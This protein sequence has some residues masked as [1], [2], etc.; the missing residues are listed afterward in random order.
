MWQ[1]PEMAEPAVDHEP[2]I[3]VI[4]DVFDLTVAMGRVLSDEQ[5]ELRTDC[6]GWTVKDQFAHIVGLEQVLVGSPHSDVELPDLDHIMNDV[7]RYMEQQVHVRRQLPLQAV[8]DELA[9]LAPRR[10]AQLR[11]QAAEGDPEVAGLMGTRRPLSAGLGIRGFDLWTHEQDI[12]RAVGLD[13]RMDCRAGQQ[14]VER[15]VGAWMAM[16]PDRVEAN[17]SMMLDVD[18]KGPVVITFGGEGSS[19]SLTM[20]G[21]VA[22]RLGCGR[23]HPTAVLTEAQ[24][25]GDPDLIA[26]VVPHLA[27]TP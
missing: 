1:H 10:I 18:G 3:G 17:G 13:A 27:F 23:G 8:V 26:A 6:P 14:A 11:S 25:S 20:S 4:E 9:G 5:G 21:E 19:I 15:T 7:G 2:S 12:R 22:T 16:L 24:M